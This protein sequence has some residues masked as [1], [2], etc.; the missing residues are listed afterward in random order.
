MAQDTAQVSGQPLL[1]LAYQMHRNSCAC[2]SRAEYC[3]M[4]GIATHTK[5]PYTTKIRSRSSHAGRTLLLPRKF[6]DPGTCP[7]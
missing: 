4:L 5:M 1:K 2:T 3:T 6:L 7:G